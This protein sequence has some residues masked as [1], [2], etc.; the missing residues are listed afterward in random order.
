M[1][2]SPH[3]TLAEFVASVKAVELGIDNSLP[4]ELLANARATA[5]MAERIRAEL[6]RISGY[7]VP[8]LI[9]SGYRCMALNTAV[10]GSKGSDHLRAQSIDW[11]APSFGTPLQIC[12]ALGPRVAGL[13]IGQLIYE[14]PDNRRWVHTSTRLPDKLV[15][16]VI[17]IGPDGPML[18]IQEV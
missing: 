12:R 5:D 1:N 18:G 11:T 3:F 6:S 15:N 14:G 8:I 9:S 4:P 7:T 16:R 10:G 2:L 13:G 17:T